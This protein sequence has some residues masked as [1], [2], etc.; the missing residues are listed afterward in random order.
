M[1]YYRDIDGICINELMH[2]FFEFLPAS[3][4]SVDKY[5]LPISRSL[6]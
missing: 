5:V 3:V 6:N 1:R 4:T 2:M